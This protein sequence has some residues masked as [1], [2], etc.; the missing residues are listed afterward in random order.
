M[1]VV[2]KSKEEW[3]KLSGKLLKDPLKNSLKNP[4]AAHGSGYLI[5]R[6]GKLETY[7]KELLYELLGPVFFGKKEAETEEELASF[8]RS[9]Y[10]IDVYGD[11][12]E[13]DEH[14]EDYQEAQQAIAEGLT[15]YGGSIDFAETA[16]AD[17]AEQLWGRMESQ[18]KKS[19]RRINTLLEE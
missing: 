1:G 15:V 8:F 12:C 6:D 2:M 18:E 5:A 14:Y 7:Q 13:G 9:H 16:L 10:G 19:F 17:L 3:E 11:F 4:P